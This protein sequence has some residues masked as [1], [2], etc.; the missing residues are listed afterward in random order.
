M[1][2]CE[3]YVFWFVLL[4]T[5]QVMNR[6]LQI[7]CKKESMVMTEQ[8][9]KEYMEALEAKME[10]YTEENILEQD[11]AS[12]LWYLRT[13]FAVYEDQSAHV[14][15]QAMVIELKKGTP[16]V[17]IIVNMFNEAEEAC[18][19]ELEKAIGE[20]NYLSPGGAFG[21]RKK[22]NR[23]Y[24]RNCWTLDKDKTMDKLVEDTVIYYEIMLEVAR[25]AY[26]GLKKI[27]TGEITYEEAV[28]QDLL[29]RAE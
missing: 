8:W 17:E 28:E 25:A 23:V 18:Y 15:V 1:E 24:L 14:M 10:T 29:R 13:L 5:L 19:D 9:A 12:K 26:T 21:I 3:E 4:M 6:Y 20:L 2:I 27:W 7:N 16:Q 11:E 22:E